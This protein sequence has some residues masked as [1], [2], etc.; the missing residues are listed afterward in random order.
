MPPLS[1]MKS[2]AGLRSL[3]RDF[4]A[5]KI[6]KSRANYPDNVSLSLGCTYNP[7][8]LYF[9]LFVCLFFQAGSLNQ[10]EQTLL[11]SELT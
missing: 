2:C 9:C 7:G 8:E 10:K 3:G 11:K 5:H 4:V 6:Q 1:N